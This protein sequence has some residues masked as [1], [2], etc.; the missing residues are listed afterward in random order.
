LIDV[1]FFK[2]YSTSC[3]QLPKELSRTWTG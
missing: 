3:Y 1:P 2:P